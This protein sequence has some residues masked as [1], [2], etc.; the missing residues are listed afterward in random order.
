MIQ[1]PDAQ[2]SRRRFVLRGCPP[3]AA[4]LHTVPKV[5]LNVVP[6][7][8]TASWKKCLALYRYSMNTIVELAT[9]R[10]FSYILHNTFTNLSVNLAIINQLQILVIPPFLVAELTHFLYGLARSKC[11]RPSSASTHPALRTCLG[12]WSGAGRIVQDVGY[13]EDGRLW[14]STDSIFR[15]L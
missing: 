9:E 1:F 14:Y 3:N 2:R 15:Y 11:C 5:S 10:K 13:S 12:P 7:N 6:P 8:M 4:Q